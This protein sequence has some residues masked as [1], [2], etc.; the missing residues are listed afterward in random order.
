MR[1]FTPLLLRTK[2]FRYFHIW[3]RLS[4]ALRVAL[5]STRA[6]RRE[7]LCSEDCRGGRERLADLWPLNAPPRTDA[8][9]VSAIWRRTGNVLWAGASSLLFILSSL[10]AS[11]A[12]D[13]CPPLM[14]RRLMRAR[15][16]AKTVQVR[17]V[18]RRP[19]AEPNDARKFCNSH[20]PHVAARLLVADARLRPHF[21]VMLL[22]I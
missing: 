18:K 8:A 7:R 5:F 3:R 19:S 9:S 11:T 6:N 13:S 12:D 1:I 15:E 21:I 2:S 14:G 17:V 10:F 4:A 16:E 22:N 20:V